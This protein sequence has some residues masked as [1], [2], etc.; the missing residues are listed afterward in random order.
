MSIKSK[1]AKSAKCAPKS[2]IRRNKESKLPTTNGGGPDNYQSS[3]APSHIGG[4]S[5]TIVGVR[6]GY[7]SVN[8]KFC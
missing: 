3:P 5:G 8:S 2:T 4:F 6:N 1:M 7:L